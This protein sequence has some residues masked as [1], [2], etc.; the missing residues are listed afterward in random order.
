MRLSEIDPGCQLDQEVKS[1]I[2][3]QVVADPKHP[4]SDIIVDEFGV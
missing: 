4:G 1:P 3:H 2:G